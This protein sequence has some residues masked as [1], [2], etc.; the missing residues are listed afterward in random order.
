[1]TNPTKS[2][3]NHI[4]TGIYCI[5]LVWIILFKM[6]T[7]SEL[8]NMSQIRHINLIPFYYAEEQSYHLSEVMK[9]VMVFIP[10]GIYFKLLK[11]RNKNAILLGAGLSLALELLQFL[12]G[13]GVTD[14][15][16]LITNTT[17]TAIGVV[18]YCV[19]ARIFRRTEWLDKV[20]QI[21]ALLC[22]LLLIAFFVLLFLAN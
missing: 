22:T 16:D 6:S 15:T 11:F 4:L 20:L 14:I 7:P 19:L 18:L 9:N 17:G 13:I 12:L 2:R 1:M 5:L 21:L 8:L 10:L 3:K